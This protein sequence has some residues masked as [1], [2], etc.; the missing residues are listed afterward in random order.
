MVDRRRR[1]VWSASAAGALDGAAQYVAADAPQA[2]A[3][4]VEKILIAADSLQLLATRGRRLPELADPTVRELLV[5]PFRLIYQIQ[6]AE[7][8]ILALVHQARDFEALR[9]N[10]GP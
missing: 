9:D 5:H 7:V 2:A 6:A 10:L 8:R 3:R 1:V 4:L